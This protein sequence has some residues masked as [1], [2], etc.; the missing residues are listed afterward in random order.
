MSTPNSPSHWS[1]VLNSALDAVGNTPLIRLDRIAK[2]EG[3]K[4]NLRESRDAPTWG[5]DTCPSRRAT[6]LS[7]F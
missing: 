3:L 5:C 4:C 1:G 6:R 7:I 2:A